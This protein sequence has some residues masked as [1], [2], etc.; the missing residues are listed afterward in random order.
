MVNI[1]HVTLFTLFF[2]PQRTLGCYTKFTNC[3]IISLFLKLYYLILEGLELNGKKIKDKFINFSSVGQN[4]Y[5]LFPL[6]PR[7]IPSL[8]MKKIETAPWNG[9]YLPRQHTLSKLFVSRL[10]RPFRACRNRS[11]HT[12]GCAPCYLLRPFGA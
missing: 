4:Y 7:K 3:L 5:P 8:A 10:F 6:A 1:R 2:L 9:R 11:L 12:R